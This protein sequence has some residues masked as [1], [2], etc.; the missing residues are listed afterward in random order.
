MPRRAD[1]RFKNPSGGS[2][3]LTA[4]RAAAVLGGALLGR[5]SARATTRQRSIK[6]RL[7]KRPLPG[8]TW[9]GPLQKSLLALGI[10]LTLSPGAMAVKRYFGPGKPAY[11]TA[12]VGRAS[13][14]STVMATGTLQAY[15]QVDVGAQVSG[16]LKS[17][18]VDLGDQVK[19]GQLLAEIDPEVLQNALVSAQANLASLEAQK[20]AVSASLWQANLALQRQQQMLA[21][22]ATS[23]QD[24]EA[25]KAQA[26]VLRANL[27]SFSAQ[28]SQ[29]RAQ[30][31]S[32]KANVAYTKITAPIDGEV[33]AI[34]TQEGQTVVASQQAP[35]ILKLADLDHM[36]VKAQ[37]SEADVIRI[38]PGQPA[39]FTIL[40][41]TDARHT[42]VLRAVE[43][44]PQD[45][46]NGDAKPSGPVFYNA[47]FETSNPDHQLRIG[48]TAQVTVGLQHA[49]NALYVPISALGRRMQDGRYPVRVL[50][51]DG[52]TTTV[53]VAAGI[54]DRVNIKVL[55]GLNE[56]DEVVT[57][58]SGG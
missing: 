1:R 4:V 24:L 35:V 5:N 31:D 55:D 33:V 25:A 6:D 44:A 19:K 21:R 47:L 32:A 16:Q 52:S 34:V 26:D 29:A 40:G 54:N 13:L 38:R 15:H 17:L 2:E 53:M 50:H 14:E 45:F 3:A 23:Q 36:T 39:Y 42:G 30:V 7:A 51:P 41:D 43:P 11:L 58:D 10:V 37:I 46:S 28:V 27:A 12:T 49:D 8:G 22:Q 48:M 56:G 18:R 9:G 20:L 57:A